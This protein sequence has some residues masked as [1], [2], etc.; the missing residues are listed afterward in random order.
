MN[1]DKEW[2]RKVNARYIKGN[3]WVMAFDLGREIFEFYP[4]LSDGV[5]AY[6]KKGLV[7]VS[8]VMLVPRSPKFRT[9]YWVELHLLHLSLEPG[10][11][12]QSLNTAKEYIFLLEDKPIIF[13][14]PIKEVSQVE[15]I[16]LECK[17]KLIGDKLMWE[18][19]VV[20]KDGK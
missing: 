14:F 20:R 1:R 5:E 18:G 8:D 9:T 7:G 11:N 15:Y 2:I 6:H 4:S 12:I 16:M 13:Q 3:A 17:M 10:Y 19:K